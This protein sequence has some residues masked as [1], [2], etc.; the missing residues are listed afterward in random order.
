M[1]RI[2][3]Y[4]RLIRLPNTFMIALA[5]AIGYIISARKLD[6][7]IELFYA[8]VTGATINSAV[9]IVNDIADIEI[10]RINMLQRPL[11]TGE[12]SIN[13]AWILAFLTSAT[14]IIASIATGPY[15]FIIAFGFL[16]LGIIYNYRLKGIPLIGNMSVSASVAIP[17]IYGGVAAGGT[18]DTNI[19]LL[20][21]SA[22]TVNTYREI[23]KDIADVEGDKAK[24][25]KTLPIVLGDNTA[26]KVAYTFLLTG[27]AAGLVPLFI[28]TGIYLPLYIPLIILTETTLLYSGYLAYK[29][30]SYGERRGMLKAKKVALLGMFLGML[31][32]LLG[33]TLYLGP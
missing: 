25:L 15:T 10:D 27:L 14:G 2:R 26:L 30:I 31:A 33:A 22:F 8:L 6:L 7:S 32:F 11:V 24:G 29:S 21:I 23:I 3:S 16:I 28:D 18:L 13:E 1:S 4:L 19:A 12:V 17:F 5:V 9:M 20:A